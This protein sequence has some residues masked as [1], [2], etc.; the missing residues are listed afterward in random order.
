MTI[1]KTKKKFVAFAIAAITIIS[2]CIP[3][4]AATGNF[5]FY[6]QKGG[7][8]SVSS[9]VI[10]S[11]SE[12]RA[13]V[14]PTDG[15][16]D[17]GDVFGFRVRTSGGSMATEYKTWTSFTRGTLNYTVLT[18]V[19]GNYYRLYGQIDSSSAWN[20]QHVEGRWTP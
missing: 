15:V 6:M 1:S 4:L 9:S 18:G 20:L 16:L 19:A 8:A 13:Y 3:A 2:Q 14:T 10:K 5:D 12:Q 7:P 17:G 11:D